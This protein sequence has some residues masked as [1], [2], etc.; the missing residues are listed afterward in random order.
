MAIIQIRYHIVKIH[1][2][3]VLLI[4]DVIWYLSLKTQVCH[5][6]IN[7]LLVELASD[8]H[9]LYTVILRLN[10]KLH[11]QSLQDHYTV[12]GFL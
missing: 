6:V 2:L 1:Q 7:S 8:L 5:I 10:I 9:L 4:I 12:K 3:Q 11:V